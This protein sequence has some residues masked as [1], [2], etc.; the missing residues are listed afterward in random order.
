[1]LDE[2][3]IISIND[4]R[5]DKKTKIRSSL[6]DKKEVFIDFVDGSDDNQL[7]KAVEKWRNVELPGPF[8]RGEFGIFFS[9]LNSL[10]YCAN[11]GNLLVFEDDAMPRED[12]QEKINLYL[13]DSPVDMDFCSIWVPEGQQ[14]DYYY[15]VIYDDG[16]NPSWTKELKYDESVY[17]VGHPY[18]SKVYQGFSLVTTFFTQKGAQKLLEYAEEKG[19]FT[20]A[21]CM[22]FIAAH[23][24]KV[25]G[26][27][28]NPRAER[29][30]D[31]DWNAPTTIHKSSWGGI[32]EFI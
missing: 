22:I 16:G 28:L 23:T 15:D 3:T 29:I 8:K 5:E 9:L 7:Q 12:F 21:D 14:R 10:E 19:M 31:Y 6:P 17:N 1:L 30:I 18:L 20:P 11:N 4:T 2:Y 13:T 25:N 24:N 26:Y 32:R 27:A